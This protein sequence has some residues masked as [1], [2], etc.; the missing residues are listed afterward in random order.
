MYPDIEMQM[1]P[2]AIACCETL[3]RYK[4]LSVGNTIMDSNILV[5]GELEFMLSKG[6][7]QYFVPDEKEQLFQNA[8]AISDLLIMVMNRRSKE[9]KKN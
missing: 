5:T 7:G 8:K 6:L 9:M 2:L 3:V 4:H 1:K